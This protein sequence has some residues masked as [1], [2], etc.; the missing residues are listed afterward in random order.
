MNHFARCTAPI[1]F[2][3]SLTCYKT[4]FE[5]D[6]TLT[7]KFVLWK[8]FVHS[9]FSIFL[10]FYQ[11]FSSIQRK[12]FGNFKEYN[13]VSWGIHEFLES[14]RRKAGLLYHLCWNV[15]VIN[16]LS[17]MRK[18]QGLFISGL[19]FDLLVNVHCSKS[20]KNFDLSGVLLNKKKKSQLSLELKTEEAASNVWTWKPLCSELPLTSVGIFA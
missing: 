15:W 8:F 3:M 1:D 7:I 16:L 20:S 12:I 6:C 19:G 17:A 10:S 2:F 14:V 13:K 5:K 18:N 9:L 4:S 11:V